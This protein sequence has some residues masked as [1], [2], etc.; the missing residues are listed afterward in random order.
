MV[1]RVYLRLNLLGRV[2][3]W[4]RLLLHPLAKPIILIFNTVIVFNLLYAILLH[5]R[6]S[7]G[8]G[9]IFDV[10]LPD[11]DVLHLVDDPELLDGIRQVLDDL[12]FLFV[13]D[14]QDQVHA[15]QQ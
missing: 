4:H 6:S 15:R 14:G 11:G 13:E 9:T 10:P 8:N 7:I 1:I 3:N 12:A 5:F 2:L